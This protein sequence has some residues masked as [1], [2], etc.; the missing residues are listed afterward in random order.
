MSNPFKYISLLLL[1][2]S[3]SCSNIKYLP[4]GEKL[5]IGGNVKI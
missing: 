5:Y 4:K 3:V 1:L 2:I